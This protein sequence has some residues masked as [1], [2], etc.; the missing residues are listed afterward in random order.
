MISIPVFM[1]H[2]I[3][4]YPEDLVTLSPREFENH[5]QVL[6]AKNIQ[7]LFLDE[8][9]DFLT[10]KKRHSRPAVALT[11]DDGHLDNWVYAFPLL[12]KYQMK[13]TIFVITSWMGSGPKRKYW[14]GGQSL[15]QGVP[16]I[17]HHREVKGRAQAGDL[18]VALQWEEARAMEASGLVDIQS[19]THFHREYFQDPDKNTHLEGTKRQELLDDLK[20]S[21]DR[22][23][24][25]LEKKCRF[26]AWPWGRYNEE[27]VALASQVGYEGIVT[28]E[29]GVNFP[30]SSPFLI[31]R[32][33]AKSGDPG[34]FSARIWIYSHSLIGNLY[35]RVVGKI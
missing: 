15:N 20:Q 34:W 16:E 26:L 18:S 25:H 7:T 13:A 10:G 22:I 30:G 9:L 5:L 28:T 12:K 4:H 6:A 29:K 23:E 1:Y 33:V 32:V 14:D 17:P 27:A 11:F 35:S 24:S 21:K 3:N 2:H 31:K 19:H 8:I